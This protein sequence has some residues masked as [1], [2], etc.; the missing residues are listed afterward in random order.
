[1]TGLERNGD[2]VSLAA[3][4]P[5]FGAAKFANQWAVD[6]M[7]YTNTELLLSANYY[8]QQIFMKNSGSHFLNSETKAEDWYEKE[9]SIDGMKF[10]KFYQAV[11]YDEAT[12]DIII[13]LVNVGKDPIT[14]NIN[15]GGNKVNAI[16]DATI[17]EGGEKGYLSINSLTD[18][19]VKP[20]LSLYGEKQGRFLGDGAPRNLPRRACSE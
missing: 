19:Q 14:A 15:L 10:D 9:T 20:L 3:Y 17:I 6:M 12:G 18:T 7:Y 13:K 8:V 11:T 5:M 4:A 1:M 2:V 16:A